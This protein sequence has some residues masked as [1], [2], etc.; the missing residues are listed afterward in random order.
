MVMLC[1]IYGVTNA[2]KQLEEKRSPTRV[3]Y[4]YTRFILKR[5]AD[6]FF[7]IPYKI[8]I[9]RGNKYQNVSKQ[10][11]ENAKDR[12][13]STAEAEFAVLDCLFYNIV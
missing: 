8:T 7:S 4:M 3:E 9:E 2:S 12:Y 1:T 13:L 5:T 10:V 11:M 6:I